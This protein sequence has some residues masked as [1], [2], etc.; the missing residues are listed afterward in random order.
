MQERRN[1]TEDDKV[2][3][4]EPGG[5]WELEAGT[6]AIERGWRGTLAT[7]TTELM[8]GRP[9]SAERESNSLASVLLPAPTFYL[10]LPLSKL[11]RKPVS[12]GSLSRSQQ[13]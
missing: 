8:L 4:C 13:S 11:P 1:Q 3:R 7:G 12:E 9:L 10:C 6:E 5:R 2:M